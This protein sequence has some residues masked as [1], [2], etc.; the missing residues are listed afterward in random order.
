MGTIMRINTE[1]A[2]LN[3]ERVFARPA[4]ILAEI[5]LTRGQK[6]ASLRRWEERVEERLAHA[7]RS[8][9]EVRSFGDEKLLREIK[10]ARARLEA[11]AFEHWPAHRS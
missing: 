9:R 10:G 4:H 7:E 2:R 3:P 11:K 1:L 8:A 6:I 5:A